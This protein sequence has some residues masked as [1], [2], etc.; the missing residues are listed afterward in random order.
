VTTA[1]EL[2]SML[3]DGDEIAVLDVREAGQ[4]GE[5][6]LL[7]ATPLAYS[8]LE[9]DVHRLVPR[10]NVRLVLCDD[11]Q[12][13][14]AKRSAARLRELGYRRVFVL[15]N[16]TRGWTA[17]G[18]ALFRG[19]NVP[20][21]TFGELVE[22]AYHTPRISAQELARMQAA[23]DD[24]IILDGRPY[25]EYHRMNIPGGVCCPNGEL[26]Y[27]I[28]TMARDPG[29][30]IVVN[31][32]GRTRS[33][34]GAQTLINCGVSNPVFALENGTQGWYLA[35][36]KLEKN[37]TRRYPDAIDAATLP[38]ARTAAQRLMQRFGARTADASE[39]ARWL[40]DEDRTTYVFDVRTPEEFAARTLA[41]ATHAPGGQLI[42]ATDQWVAVRHARIVLVDSDGVRAPVVASWLAQLGYE[43][44]VLSEGIDA[45]LQ[46]RQA[47]AI[48]L[49]QLPGMSAQA[50]KQALERRE[51]TALDLRN[52]QDY[53][54]AH[55]PG[56]RWSIRRRIVN[57][58]RGDDISGI[59]LIA[60]EPGI[61]Q[62]AA[63][64][65]ISAGRED[66]RYID[67]GMAAWV[68]A[69]YGAEESPDVPPDEECIDHLF[70]V[71]D[72]HAGNREAM[73][74]Y[75]AWETGLLAQL[76]E[77]DRAEFRLPVTS[78]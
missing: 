16:G 1:T 17:A 28:A 67:G 73:R 3:H 10:F 74:Q 55:V 32:A 4:F 14:V 13:G 38:A 71:H 27:R 42:Q 15:E 48:T 35:D 44:A 64:D 59:A 40:E 8:R 66:V 2:K 76:D 60:A 50:L 54:Q 20:S 18:L 11:G 33:I 57:D 72:R 5:G 62:L 6:H 52:S 39:V 21:K 77:Q 26:P 41:G 70:F 49:P 53:R 37:A 47:P 23:G 61:A 7:F 58:L 24:L 30:K 78:W 45:R 19:V 63:I 69:G 29:T 68:N 34:L 75:L 9:L 22:H 31:C 12:S 46:I 65:L 51:I 56:S 36:Y 43:C 25:A